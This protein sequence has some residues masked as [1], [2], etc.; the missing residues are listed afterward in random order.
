MCWTLPTELSTTRT[1]VSKPTAAAASPVFDPA[2]TPVGARSVI[3]R[4]AP[5]RVWRRLGRMTEEPRVQGVQA[6]QAMQPVRLVS[7]LRRRR[8]C[9]PNT[10]GGGSERRGGARRGTA[11]PGVGQLPAVPGGAARARGGEPE[12]VPGEGGAGGGGLMPSSLFPVR[13]DNAG[14][15]GRVAALWLFALVLLLKAIMGVNGAIN[16]RRIATGDGFR[17]DEGGA[18][19]DPVPLPE[20]QPRP[21]PRSPLSAPLPMALAVAGAVPLPRAPRGPDLAPARRDGEP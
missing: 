11:A 17:L 18:E 4:M 1:N 19:I 20:R 9:P 7:Q 12:V 3:S 16:T 21:V 5:Q 6:V 15:R 8:A 13:L 14:Y 2:W 10:A